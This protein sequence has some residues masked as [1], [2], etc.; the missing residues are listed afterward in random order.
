MVSEYVYVGPAGRGTEKAVK[1]WVERGLE[2]VATVE[3][4][5]ARGRAPRIIKKAFGA[6]IDARRGC[7]RLTTLP[8][9]GNARIKSA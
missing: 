6:K 2:F 1:K 8:K 4:K 9:H 7:S 5:K 3:K